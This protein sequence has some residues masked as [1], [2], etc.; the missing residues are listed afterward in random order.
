MPHQYFFYQRTVLFMYFLAT[1][2]IFLIP[3]V[4]FV[5]LSPLL[6]AKLL[7]CF[8]LWEHVL[9]ATETCHLS[10][11]NMLFQPQK[12][13]IFCCA[14]MPFSM[15]I[16]PFTL[17]NMCFQHG[18]TSLQ[19]WKNA[20]LAIGTSSC[21]HSACSRLQPTNSFIKYIKYLVPHHP[22]F[23]ARGMLYRVHTV[24]QSDLIRVQIPSSV[25]SKHVPKLCNVPQP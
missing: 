3:M 10:N 15:E 13:A 12:Q 5:P 11:G 9:L 4:D 2:L 1:D 22:V 23:R 19:L 8:Q 17:G 18:Y 21:S 16:R 7:P 14:N 20:P 24:I 25:S 6:V